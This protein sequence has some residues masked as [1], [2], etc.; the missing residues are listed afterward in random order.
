MLK[1]AD[2][3]A[4]HRAGGLDIAPY[5][6]FHRIVPA[7]YPRPPIADRRCEVLLSFFSEVGADP[8]VMGCHGRRRSRELVLGGASRTVL[9]SLTRPVLMTH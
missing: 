8:L 9:R 5:L 1:T 3:P 6:H 7:L 4:Q 2:D